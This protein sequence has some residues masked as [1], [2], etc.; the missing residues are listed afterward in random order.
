MGLL[1]NLFGNNRYEDENIPA[2][3]PSGAID[4]IHRGVL[5]SIN[6]NQLMMVGDEVCHYAERA[7]RVT[8]KRTKHYEGG[9]QGVSIR[10]MKGVTYRVGKNKG[11]PV[12]DISNIKTKGLLY[13]TDKRIVFVS[14]E[15]AFEKK[16]KLLTACVPY[17]NAV[18]LQFGNTTISLLIPDGNVVYMVISMISQ[19]NRR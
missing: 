9:S 16:F 5:P 7:I 19:S 15:Q 10:I 17:S 4:Q 11:V 12:E 14:D 1:A 13:I 3:M 2:I 8:E 6:T 18:K